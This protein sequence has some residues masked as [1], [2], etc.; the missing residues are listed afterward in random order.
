[1][2]H[3]HRRVY[4]GN[5]RAAVEDPFWDSPAGRTLFRMLSDQTIEE[6][7]QQIFALTNEIDSAPDAAVVACVDDPRGDL[8]ASPLAFAGLLMT[9][10]VRAAIVAREP[11]PLDPSVPEPTPE[12]S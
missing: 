4:A 7:L 3:L 1:M 9:P 10:F 12:G 6:L 11:E 8:R 5:L 2:T